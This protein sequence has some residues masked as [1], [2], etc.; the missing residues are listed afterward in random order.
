MRVIPIV[1][2]VYPISMMDKVLPES[3]IERTDYC[4]FYLES[5]NHTA[6]YE[7]IQK[8][9]SQNGFPTQ[10]FYD[11]AADSE[12][13]KNLITIIQ[14]FAYGFVILIS[15]ISVA[16]VFNTIS[17]NISLRRREFAM[18]KSVGMTKKDFNKMMNFECLIY[19]IKALAL[20]L[21][22]SFAVTYIIYS[23]I[24]QGFGTEFYLPLKAVAIAVISVFLVVFVTMLYAMRKIKKDNP[25]DALKN[26][27]L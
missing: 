18:L 9:L 27:N 23:A 13:N 10:T 8:N 16:N 4:T 17:T 15:L 6:S 22:V 24:T 1:R 12:M 26:E 14:V 2:F 21:P 5:D 25:I 11:V 3:E 19:G 20:G 7:R